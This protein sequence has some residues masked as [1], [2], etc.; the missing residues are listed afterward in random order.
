MVPV[1]A[2]HL[3]FE[4]AGR[5]SYSSRK[6]HAI[7]TIES[8]CEFR[9]AHGSDNEKAISGRVSSDFDNNLCRRGETEETGL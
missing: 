6:R 3:I 1:E 4:N 8:N 2:N 5:D 9:D 7:F